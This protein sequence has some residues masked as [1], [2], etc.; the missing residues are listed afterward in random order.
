[1]LPK[2]KFES[3]KERNIY[4]GIIVG[5]CVLVMLAVVFSASGMTDV[6]GGDTSVSGQISYILSNPLSFALMFIKEIVRYSIDYIF[7]GEGKINFNISGMRSGTTELVTVITLVCLVLCGRSVEKTKEIS[8][9]TSVVG[10]GLI[11]IVICFI[12]GS[13]YL[14]YTPVGSGIIAG[15]Q[16]RHYMPFLF[17]FFML[18]PLNKIKCYISERIIMQGTLVM[19]ILINVVCMY[20]LLIKP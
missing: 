7:N 9:K 8:L 11:G 10:L 18:L 1:M 15:V 12:W 4:R 19:V 13:M 17:M 2:S 20:G 16:A 14:S 6:R 3:K 5:C